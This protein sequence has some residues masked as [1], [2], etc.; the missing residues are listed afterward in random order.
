MKARN[1]LKFIATLTDCEDSW[2][3]VEV[4]KG[5]DAARVLNE[6]CNAILCDSLDFYKDAEYFWFYVRENENSFYLEESKK[7]SYLERLFAN[8]DKLYSLE[9]F[10]DYEFPTKRGW[11]VLVE[12]E[13]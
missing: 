11:Y 12:V 3:L 9:H 7:N 1:I 2:G 8:E 4:K 10:A 13:D 5:D 6:S